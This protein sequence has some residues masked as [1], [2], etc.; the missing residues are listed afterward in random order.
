MRYFKSVPFFITVGILIF[1]GIVSYIF[2]DHYTIDHNNPSNIKVVQQWDL[3]RIMEEVSGINYLEDGRMACVQD[4]EGKIFIYNLSDNKIDR[5]I[6]FA[7]KGDFE[8][9]A[10]VGQKAYVLRSDGVLFEV[11]DIRAEHPE[12]IEHNTPLTEDQ[13][14]EGLCYDEANNRLLLAIKDTEIQKG[15]D[16]KGIYA[17]D[18]KTD[19]L[20]TEPVYKLS[21]MDPIFVDLNDM[22]N[23]DVFRPSEIN[24]HPKTGEI[25]LLDAEVPK[26]LILSKDWKPKALYVFSLEDFPQPE[27]ITFSPEGRMFISNEG[28][29]NPANILEVSIKNQKKDSTSKKTKN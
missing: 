19:E 24:I 7:N 22:G 16:Y 1:V 28:E 13:N 29:W 27:G 18:L 2:R 20:D 5:T 3:P 23:S 6:N 21:F 10:V 14:V 4:E 8:G 9:I 17:F 11:A 15:A 26:M 12:V 25:Y